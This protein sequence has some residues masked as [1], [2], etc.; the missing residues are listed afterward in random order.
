MAPTRSKLRAKSKQPAASCTNKRPSLAS[1]TALQRALRNAAHP[2]RAAS[3]AKFFKTG[4]G[5]YGEGD[6]FIGIPVPVL[7]RIARQHL[8]LDFADLKQL[9]ASPIHEYRSA[10][11]E[12]LVAQYGR[13]DEAQRERIVAFYLRHTHRMNNWDLVDAAA[14][15]I[16]GRHLKT[17]PRKV[18]HEF[19][20]SP[21]LWERRI[22]IVAT[23]ALVRNG[24]VAETFRIAEKLLDDKHDLIHKAV[25]WALRESGK[26]STEQLV[27]FLQQHYK[28]LPRTTLRYAIERFPPRQRRKLL[29]GDFLKT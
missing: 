26:I 28:H 25:G 6:R 8:L 7:R 20:V 4:K 11:L 9:L 12:I 5:E 24:D 27:A 23:L 14:P 10:A 29:A 16:L 2:K 18:L 3:V 19:A 21:N 13:A 17:R 1:R 15:Y 22:A